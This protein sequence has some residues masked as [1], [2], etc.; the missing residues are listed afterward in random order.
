MK[1]R[2]LA[3]ICFVLCACMVMGIGY[4][5]LSRT[6]RVD[7]VMTISSDVD[8]FPV[9]FTGATLVAGAGNT[10]VPEGALTAT[11]NTADKSIVD[12][13]IANGALSEIGDTL[14]LTLTVEN[15]ATLLEA[16]V[17][18]PAVTSNALSDYITITSE[19]AGG[20]K[21]GVYNAEGDDDQMT[22]VMTFTLVNPLVEDKID[23]AM[24]SISIVATASAPAA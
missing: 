17:A 12:V 8:N 14:V 11:V 7:G 21:L 22:I 10:N 23:Q 9:E 13:R 16:T 24:F 5:A 2:R 4:A 20:N 15:K 19:Y 18:A 1:K 6:L 3:I